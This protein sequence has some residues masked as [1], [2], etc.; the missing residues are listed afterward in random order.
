MS[1]R[2]ESEHPRF[3][4][5]ITA[6]LYLDDDEYDSSPNGPLTHAKWESVMGINR[7]GLALSDLADV[8]FHWEHPA[9]PERHYG[10]FHLT[11]GGGMSAG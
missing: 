6:R 3:H 10:E 7:P 2:S 11:E 4:V 5:T 8:V 1:D 9:E